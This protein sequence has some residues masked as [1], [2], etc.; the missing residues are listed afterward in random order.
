MRKSTGV[1]FRGE[2]VLAESNIA[3]GDLLSTA[4]AA[5][6]AGAKVLSDMAR[7]RFA[8]VVKGNSATL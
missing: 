2:L 5:A 4:P 8:M 1:T 7:D 3:Y 6:A